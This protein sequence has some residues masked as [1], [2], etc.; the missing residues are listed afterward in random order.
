MI[1]T[2]YQRCNGNHYGRRDFLRIGSL[3]FLG[4]S[5]SRYLE[6]RH[7]MA[8]SNKASKGK[9][10]ACILLWLDG[11][12]SQMDTW[13]PKPSSSFKPISTNVPGIQI[14]ELLPQLAKQM[15]KLSIIRSM[16]TEENNHGIAHHY[17][18]TGHK[19]NPAMKFPGFGSII[20]KELGP[21]NDIPAHVM[22]PELG[23][24][25][26]DYFRAHFLGS[27]YDPM[28]VPDPNP[29]K[30][31]G[32]GAIADEIKDFQVAD[33][34]LPKTVTVERLQQRRSF[35]KM[36]DEL[37]RSKVEHA[38]YANMDT[39]T[40]QAWDMILSK[41]V[42]AAFDLSK[43]PEK[44]KDAYGRNAFGQSVL[45]ARRLVEAGSRFVTA[46]GYKFQAWDTHWNNNKL[47]QTVLA[48]SLDQTLSTLLVDLHERGLLESTVVLA[49]GEFGRT[50]DV[51]PD[52][53]RDHW[54][55]CWSL[56]LG[57]GGIRGGRVVG[58]SD[59]KGAYPAEHMVTIGDL[60]A[61]IYKALGIDWRKEYM[62]PIGRP[63]KIANS[64][65][66]E[67]GTPVTDLI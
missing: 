40:Q 39:F 14:S 49:M 5:L 13:D 21:R 48:P 41:S 32:V 8:A 17:A 11:G 35:L 6:L 10:E 22:V 15:D 50:D 63:L 38:E 56:A 61:T 65:N 1:E 45:L 3:S 53:G 19:P 47:M 52:G 57:G 27:Q 51:N 36:V 12:P 31:G 28:V 54:C 33:L 62:H 46:S 60:Y 29:P 43:E 25:R 42:R 64:I 4:I 34:S 30:P 16:H 59:E 20:T 18:I 2:S 37:Y 24:S 67:T 55:H 23:T 9:A 66:D 58:A 26:E 7:L 44:V